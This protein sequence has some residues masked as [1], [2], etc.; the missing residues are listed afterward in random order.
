MSLLVLLVLGVPIAISLAI[1][2]VGGIILTQ[3]LN[4]LGVVP[5]VCFSTAA[6]YIL[7]PV[8][9]FVF[10]GV[11]LERTGITEQLYKVLY[12]WLGGFKGGLAIVTIL[13][14]TVMAACV[15]IITASVAML[16]LVALPSM[17]ERGYSKSLATGAICAGGTL[18]ILIPPSIMLIIYGPM[19]N[20]S[21]GKMF[22]GAF[23]PGFI[24][25]GLY[26][27]YIIIRCYIQ[28]ELAPVVPTEQRAIPFV[29]KTYMLITA[30]LPVAL[31]ITAVL[32]SI[33]FGIA[34]PTQAAAVGA[35]ASVLLAIAYRR[36]SWQNLK[37]VTLVTLKMTGFMMLIGVAAF[38]FVGVFIGGGCD[39]VVKEIIINFPGGRWGSFFAI[40]FICFILGFMMDWVGILFLL[41]PILAPIAPALG[42]N[43]LWFGIMICVNLQMSFL[44]PPFAPAIFVV[45]G[46]A[47]PELGVTMGDIIRGVFPF[48]A[49]VV[50]GLLLCAAFPQLILWLPSQMIK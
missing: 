17:V 24:L 48:V 16:S 20:I 14:G 28:P 30:L 4:G 39:T 21:V 6:N 23:I 43:P 41:V 12:V 15:G 45:R 49:L 47:R 5:T 13:I 35:F 36:F 37:E 33:F 22:F 7:S 27:T 18:G 50:V 26:C 2:G 34:P 10:M 40:M 42:F 32:G 46:S 44:T 3:G 19:A 29:K 38:C 11:M 8:P 9:L 1:V 25:S 31:L